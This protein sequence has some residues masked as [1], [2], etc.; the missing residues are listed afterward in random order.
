MSPPFSRTTGSQRQKVSLLVGSWDLL[1]SIRSFLRFVFNVKGLNMCF[2]G[3]G[4]CSKDM[5]KFSFSGVATQGLWEKHRWVPMPGT[6][7]ACQK[8]AKNCS[9]FTVWA[10]S[11]CGWY[12]MRLYR[13][14][15]TYI[16]KQSWLR[17]FCQ[18]K[19]CHCSNCLVA[20]WKSAD[21]KH[22]TRSSRFG[23]IFRRPHV[24]LPS[25][26]STLNLEREFLCSQ[27]Q[28]QDEC[29]FKRMFNHLGVQLRRPLINLHRKCSKIPHCICPIENQSHTCCQR[30]TRIA[31]TTPW[32]VVVHMDKFRLT[33][34][35]LKHLARF[36]P[37]N[38]C[39]KGH[40]INQFLSH[41]KPKKK[42]NEPWKRRT[43]ERG[44]W[45]SQTLKNPIFSHDLRS[46][47]ATKKRFGSPNRRQDQS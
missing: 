37:Q 20:P 39:S 47:V 7:A 44:T 30:V 29:I 10:P 1:W 18:G 17:F 46:T 24:E 19:G 41:L 35:E 34:Q 11:K 27:F 5:L 43:P 2:F 42:M 16:Y 36:C 45:T 23:W 40:K 12:G 22:E 33:G 15:C 3:S 32:V 26:I 6:P 13:Y 31:Y 25:N 28:N 38:T 14:I 8:A 9:S 4:V 21:S